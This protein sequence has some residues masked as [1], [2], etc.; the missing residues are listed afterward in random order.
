MQVLLRGYAI[1]LDFL[2]F[3]YLWAVK[4]IICLVLSCLV[5]AGLVWSHLTI[6]C[7]HEIGVR[8]W[9]PDCG[10]QLKKGV[11]VWGESELLKP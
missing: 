2:G 6:C 1:E 11:V 9:R 4:V 10:E 5:L 3:W 8:V 7:C